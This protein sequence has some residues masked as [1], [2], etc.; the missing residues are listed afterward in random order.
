MPT[1]AIVKKQNLGYIL[2]EESFMN[3]APAHH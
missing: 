1:L 3:L 2:T